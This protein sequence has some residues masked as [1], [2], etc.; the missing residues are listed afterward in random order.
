MDYLFFIEFCFRFVTI[1]AVGF[2][3]SSY[4]IFF[5]LLFGFNF[6]PLASWI[7]TMQNKLWMYGL[8][9]G[10]GSNNSWFCLGLD[11]VAFR[12][13][14]CVRSRWF[15]VCVSLFCLFLCFTFE[16]LIL[17]AILLYK[18]LWVCFSV[19]VLILLNNPSCTYLLCNMLWPIL[20]LKGN[21]F[22][23]VG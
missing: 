12:G 22:L 8:C 6:D 18:L 13:F 16:W 2:S 11:N 17:C 23:M 19:S 10:P 20:I 15:L 7:K 9:A 3:C 21:Y 14:W 5:F 4:I 1:F